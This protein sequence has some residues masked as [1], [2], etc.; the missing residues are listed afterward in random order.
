METVNTFLNT[1]PFVSLVQLD[2]RFAEDGNLKY[3]PQ[4]MSQ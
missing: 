1:K 2:F 4:E 3:D